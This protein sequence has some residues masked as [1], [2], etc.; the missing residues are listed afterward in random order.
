MLDQHHALLRVNGNNRDRSGMG[1]IVAFNPLTR[2][3]LDLIAHDIPYASFI[4]AVMGDDGLIG[5][6]VAGHLFPSFVL[7][8]CRANEA[9]IQRVRAIRTRLIF[10]MPLRA[11]IEGVNIARQ[12]DHFNKLL[13]G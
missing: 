6:L 8:H 11:H 9:G 5:G 1:N 12:F 3:Q 13:I 4:N 7:R 10:R 2:R